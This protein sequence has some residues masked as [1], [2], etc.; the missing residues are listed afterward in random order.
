MKTFYKIKHDNGI[1]SGLTKKQVFKW[2]KT[3]IVESDN[4]IVISKLN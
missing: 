3:I 2:L 1:V 4:R